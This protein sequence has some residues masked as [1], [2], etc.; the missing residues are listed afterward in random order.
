MRV[1]PVTVAAVA[2]EVADAALALPGVPRVAVDGAVPADTRYVADAVA[3]A[4]TARGRPVARVDAEDFLRP[5]SLRLEHGPADPDA[6]YERWYD[7]HAL[8]REVLEPLGPDGRGDWLPALWDAA[9]DRA[10]RA[11]RVPA[12]PGT[13][14]VVSGPFL[15]RW[16]TVH[17]VDYAVHLLTSPAA[18]ARRVPAAD[19]DRVRG[20]W[21][22]YT[23]ETDPA[24]RADVV[25]RFDR[26]TAPARVHPPL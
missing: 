19:L 23:A 18:I 26:P 9:A 22:R 15:L 4:L 13:V 7:W 14:A 25:L 21:A 16:E 5:R 24:S 20:A 1:E 8:L 2:A 10:T 3:A 6:G 17:A 12:R 11:A